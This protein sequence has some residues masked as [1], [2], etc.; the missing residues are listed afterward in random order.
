MVGFKLFSRKTLFFRGNIFIEFLKNIND[1][2]SRRFAP[3]ISHLVAWR[4]SLDAKTLGAR[5]DMEKTDFAEKKLSNQPKPKI[6]NP[7]C[8]ILKATLKSLEII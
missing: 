6:Q 1:E 8:D 7:C 4:V 5:V 2:L 3:A